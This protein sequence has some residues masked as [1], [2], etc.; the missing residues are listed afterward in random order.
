MK[1]VILVIV[2]VAVAAYIFMVV[3]KNREAASSQYVE[4]PVT[5]KPQEPEPSQKAPPVKYPV[6]E[7][8]PESAP[9]PEPAPA[10]EPEP[11]PAL[12][13]SDDAI[14]AGLSSASGEVRWGELFLLKS[15]VRHFVVTVDNMTA[16]KLPRK[17]RLTP[18]LRGKYLVQKTGDNSLI[19]SPDNYVRYEPYVRLVETIDLEKLA[20]LYR[21]YYPLFQQAYEELGY[22][23]RYFNDRLIEVID[24]LLMTPEVKGPIELRQPKVFYVF[25]DPDLEA[26]SAGQKLMVRIGP[27]NA[28]RIKTRLRVLRML[29]TG[30]N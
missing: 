18:D 4:Q 23:G 26:L 28:A 17:Y 8:K 27:H 7:V 25:A 3:K 29:L 30:N 24:H 9:E 5:L 15:I 20:A 12:D 10:P 6:T 1:N 14:V 22:P 11:L 16:T 21:R 19:I 13:E 2:I